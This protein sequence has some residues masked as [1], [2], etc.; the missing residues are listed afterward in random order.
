MNHDPETAGTALA[1]DIAADFTGRRRRRNGGPVP[2]PITEDADEGDIALRAKA[3]FLKIANIEA[4]RDRYKTETIQIQARLAERDD[5]IAEQRRTIDTYRLD[6][7]AANQ[8]TERV[9]VK[10]EALSAMVRNMAS[11][12]TDTLKFIHEG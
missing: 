6:L 9:R 11:V 7:D 3:F 5:S 4:E 12:T 10:Y 2:S 1:T 8:R